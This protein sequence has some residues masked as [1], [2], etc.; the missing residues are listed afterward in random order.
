MTGAAVQPCK[1]IDCAKTR[2]LLHLLDFARIIVR[3]LA[4]DQGRSSLSVRFSNVKRMEFKRRLRHNQTY[5]SVSFGDSGKSGR[6]KKETVLRAVPTSDSF[7]SR[8]LRTTPFTS[9]DDVAWRPPTSA[10]EN[11][12]VAVKPNR[13]IPAREGFRQEAQ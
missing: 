4:S 5:R 8:G 13:T 12:T 3:R 2:K 10:P 9:C 7:E 11:K 6:M 1:C